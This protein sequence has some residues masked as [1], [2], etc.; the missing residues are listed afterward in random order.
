MPEIGKW[1]WFDYDDA[2]STNDT[3]LT[4]SQNPSAEYFVVTAKRQHN[5]R[6][7]RGRSWISQEGNLFMSLGLPF[8]IK[9]INALVFITALSLFEA[10]ASQSPQG[11]LQLKWPND[12]LFNNQKISGILLEKG[13]QNYIIVGIGVNI[14]T[15]PCLNDQLLYRSASL[16]SAGININRVD[17]MSLFL[18]CFDRNLSLWREQGFAPIRIKWLQNV[19]GLGEDIVVNNEKNSRRGV[20]AGLDENGALLLDENGKISK[21]W[22]GDIFYQT[23]HKQRDKV[24]DE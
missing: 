23:D 10:V 18:S 1:Q 7:R 6:G 15:S 5:G 17:L 20:F 14:L 22:A 3:A 8:D 16:H 13:F 4:L 19:K 24:T 2:D 11:C 9:D 21:I 12:V